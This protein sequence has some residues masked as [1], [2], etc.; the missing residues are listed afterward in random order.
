MT[1]ATRTV[2]WG[3]SSDRAKHWVV[4]VGGL[5]VAIVG[6]YVLGL[7]FG[8]PEPQGRTVAPI[9]IDVLTALI[10]IGPAL[11]SVLSAYRRGGLIASLAIGGTPTVGAVVTELLGRGLGA[12]GGDEIGYYFLVYLLVGI[13]GALA[14]FVIGAVLRKSIHRFA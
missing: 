7:L 14:G 3:R 6:V 5:F 12:V 2:V 9:A 10:F 8:K 1:S 13:S 4:F 11:V